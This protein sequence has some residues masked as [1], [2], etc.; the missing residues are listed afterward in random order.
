MKKIVIVGGGIAVTSKQG[1]KF[2]DSN[3]D[4]I[5]LMTLK[6]IDTICP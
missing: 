6:H 4:E 3:F 2:L 5:K 1:G